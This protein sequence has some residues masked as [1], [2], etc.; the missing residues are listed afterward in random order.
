MPGGA[1][2]IQRA[3]ARAGVASRRR[4]EELIAAGRVTVNGAPARIGQTVEIGRDEIRVDGAVVREPRGAVWIV[5]H[6]PAGVMTTRADPRGRRTVFDLVQDIPGLTYVGRLDYMTEG[7]ILL[8]TD[9]D[10][11]NRLMHPSHAIERT[12][13]AV[14]QGD[15]R[16]AV[17][18]AKRGVELDDGP[19]R[20]THV[21]SRS[22]G[23]GRHEFE[24]TIT[25][26]RKREIRRLC[27]ALD[28]RLERLLRVRYGPVVLGDLAPGASRELTDAERAALEALTREQHRTSA[29]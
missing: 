7:L 26:G 11:A 25:E 16:A 15:A 10:A 9:G 19:V 2:R 27:R 18:R 22:L 24:V 4:S 3:L 21:T 12:Y 6:K 17:A 1:M 14:V 29:V 8:T 20:P 28:L 23:G 5:L 13:V